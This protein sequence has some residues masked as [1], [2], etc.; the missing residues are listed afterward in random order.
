MAMQTFYQHCMDFVA[1][2]PGNAGRTDHLVRGVGLS[3]AL[4]MTQED[5][6]ILTGK[7][8]SPL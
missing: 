2:P 1:S 3:V 6:D 8:F 5:R 4:L 7:F